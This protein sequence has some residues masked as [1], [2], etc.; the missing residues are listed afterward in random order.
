MDTENVACAALP[1][2]SVQQE[3]SSLGGV[4]QSMRDSQLLPPFS[5]PPH[6][7][8][9]SRKRSYS[10]LVSAQP[11]EGIGTPTDQSG[12][13]SGDGGKACRRNEEGGA[14]DGAKE[15]GRGGG[16]PSFQAAD[17]SRSPSGSPSSDLPAPRVTVTTCEKQQ[18]QQR[19]VPPSQ[20][21]PP[22]SSSLP[23]PPPSFPL[24]LPSLPRLP[25]LPPPFPLSPASRHDGIAAGSLE[26]RPRERE[27]GSLAGNATPAGIGGGNG[28]M[29]I[30]IRTATNLPSPPQTLL[31]NGA[32]RKWSSDI[33]KREYDFCQLLGA[34]QQEIV[35]AI[36]EKD[37]ERSRHLAEKASRLVSARKRVI[38]IADGRGWSCS[39]LFERY[40]LA[41]LSGNEEEKRRI[42]SE[43]EYVKR[44]SRLLSGGRRRGGERKRTA[45]ARPP[46]AKRSKII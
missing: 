13:M 7:I 14:A 2:N 17:S 27:P 29:M 22:F 4:K 39:E 24:P 3:E 36:A 38:E 43:E 40:T 30:P 44:R 26:E 19:P 41:E 6:T 15:E 21:V 1:P 8:D 46:T 34:L 23:L 33:N 18:Q 42:V 5:A 35:S 11:E 12:P 16:L 9:S 28:P 25:H 31:L 20:T 10:E 32:K 37:A 45:I